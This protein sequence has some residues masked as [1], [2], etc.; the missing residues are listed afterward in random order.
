[1]R[2]AHHRVRAEL[3]QL[4]NPREPVFVNLVP[5]VDGAV[6]AHAQ[7]DHQRQ[8]IDRK[9]R[10]RGGLDLGQQVAGVGLLD[11]EF[12][13]ASHHGH[14]AVRAGFVL[15][16][17][18]ELGEGAHDQIKVVGQGLGDPHLAA[19]DGTEGEEGDDLVVI[20]ADGDVGPVERGDTVDTQH[21]G[22]EPLDFRAHGDERG[23]EFL[24][25][26]FAGGV[27]QGGLALGERGGHGEVFRHGHG[28]V[29]APVARSLEARRQRDDQRVARAHGGTE[30]GEYFQMRVDLAHAER[31]AL[32]IG[33]KRDAA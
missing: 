29:V 27:D 31:A 7:R 10:P 11:F 2:V 16:H 9:I 22:A 28:H 18:A 4:G 21:G 5:K 26:G 30:G 32:G 33:Q 14:V 12:L 13:A 20:C 15:D 17:D 3:R 23:A 25:V 19:G 1:M 6:A 24:H 8:Q